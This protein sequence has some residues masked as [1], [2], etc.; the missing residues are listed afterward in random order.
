M[1]C[2]RGV[3]VVATVIYSRNNAFQA[4][5]GQA[6]RGCVDGGLSY[7][8]KARTVPFRLKVTWPDPRRRCTLTIVGAETQRCKA[9]QLA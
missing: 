4:R 2:A 1:W 5:P 7:V 3:F 6:R 8:R 9:M